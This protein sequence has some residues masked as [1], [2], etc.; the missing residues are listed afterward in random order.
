MAASNPAV[1]RLLWSR[2]AWRH[3]RMSPVSSALL[4]LILSVGVAA[5]FAIRLANRAAVE[6]FQNFTD[7]VT[8]QSDG[9]IMAPAGT[10]SGRAG[11]K[12]KPSA[13]ARPFN[14][15]GWTCPR[16]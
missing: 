3:W 13:R 6:S 4:L 16:W 11:R 15:S 2:F 9:L 8:S 10:L 7:L 12:M 5:F 14:C 1:L